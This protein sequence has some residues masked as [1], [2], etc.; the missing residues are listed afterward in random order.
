VAGR[1]VYSADELNVTS[2]NK[3]IV[4]DTD[5]L[6][7]GLYFCRVSGPSFSETLRFVKK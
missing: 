4:V 7:Q 5:V 1:E 3:N 6:T 2:E